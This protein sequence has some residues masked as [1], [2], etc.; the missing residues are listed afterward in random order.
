[1]EK[2]ESRK[3]ESRL[4]KWMEAHQESEALGDGWGKYMVWRWKRLLPVL[5]S[6]RVTEMPYTE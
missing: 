3:R 5:P 4:M 2:T 1:M 6:S